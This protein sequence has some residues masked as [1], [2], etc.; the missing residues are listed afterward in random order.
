MRLADLFGMEVSLEELIHNID[1]KFGH[2]IKRFD[3][4][5][6][7]TNLPIEDLSELLGFG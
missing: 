2:F 4:G 3:Q 6:K 1:Q 7:K 5:L